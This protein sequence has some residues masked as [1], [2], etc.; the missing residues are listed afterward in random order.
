MSLDAA[1]LAL[2]AGELKNTLLDAKIDKIFEPTRD[3]VLITLRTRTE[4]HRLLLSARSGSARVCLTRESFENPLTPPG[5]CML[6]RKHLQNGRIVNISQ[7]GLE[8]I[9]HIDIEHL[10]EMGDL[11]HKT[12]VMELMG[13]H[14]NL[15][16]C[17]DD[18]TIIDSI[19]R[20]SAAVSSVREVLPGKPYFIAHTQDKLDALT[21][22]ETTFRETL[23][24]K[25]QP[26]FKAIYG[27]FTGISPVLAQEL[28]H[29]AGID[30]EHPTAALTAEDYHAL[31]EVFS[32]MVTSIKEETFSPCIAY[33]GTRPVEYAAVPLTMYS[34]G[35][36][37][38]ESY[39][40][41]SALLEHFY[42]E[43]NTLTRIRQKSSDLR[44]IVQ[45]ALE[46]EIKKYDLQLAQM[47][48]TEK[49]EKYRIYG[50]LLNTYGY[51]AKPGDKSLTAVNYYTS[52]P[53]T[54]PL[55]PTLSATENAKKYFDKYGKLKRTYEA[56][57]ELTTQVK[58]EIDHLETISTALDIA[59][60]EEDLVEIKE[61]LTQSGYIR[62]KGGTKKAKITSKPFHYLSSD[63][64]HIYVGKNN[65]QNDELT[66]KFANGNDWWFHAK[67]IPGSHVV[68]K[69]EGKELP[70]RTF[71]EAG[72]LAAYYSKGREQEK[73]EIDYV[74][75]KQ[76]KKPA[77]AKPGFVVYYTNYSLM[78]DSDISGIEKISD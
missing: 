6:L 65:F 23:A 60:K 53:V 54:I 59:M 9:V 32:K 4:T 58:E 55:D 66:F 27:S 51:S 7:P 16:F 29:E 77:G 12:L 64:F 38:L 61:E 50:E 44:R 21:C 42:A 71:E 15:I 75:K 43:K 45:T 72:R 67:G 24:A 68:V 26:V 40:S 34:T 69:T 19:K 20:V 22:D 62:R 1:T 76:V 11:R 78:I 30:G 3:E 39:T 36:D 73:V 5:F 10:D 41:I 13:K 46:R 2:V 52:E 8:R 47:K 25:P 63:G 18:N 74:Q 37:H 28:C 57:S 33:T 49:R 35:A 48:D 17:N 56:L 31:Y 70:D 14:S